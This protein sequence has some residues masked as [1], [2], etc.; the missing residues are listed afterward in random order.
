MVHTTYSADVWPAPTASGPLEATVRLPG[1][2]SLT[3]RELVLSALADRPSRLRDALVA[4]DTDLMIA[5]LRSFGVR[6]ERDGDD[7][8]V[9]PGPLAGGASIDVGLAGTLMRFLPPLAALTDGPVRFDGDERARLRPM[10]TTILSLRALG[11]EVDDD[12][13]AT[14]P[15]IVEGTGRVTGGPVLLDASESSQFVSGLLLSGPRFDDGLEIEHRGA[16]LPS[17]P[18]IEMTI[19]ALRRRGVGVRAEVDPADRRRALAGPP[20][21]DRRPGGRDRARPVERRAIPRRGGRRRRAG[22]RAGLAGGDDPGR[23]PAARLA[24]RVRRRGRAAKRHAHVAGQGVAAHPLR[25]VELD[26][27]EGG[28]L[29][30]T[31][32]GLAA[33]ADGTSTFTGIG[34]LRGHETDRLAAL[35]T[36]L[37]ALGIAVEEPPTGS[38]CTAAA[39]SQA[40]ALAQLRRPP[41]G[42][43]GSAAR[44]RDAR[45]RGRGRRDDREDPPGVRRPVAADAPV[46]WMTDEDEPYEEYDESD[47]RIRPNR[48]GTRPRTKQRPA[49]DAAVA[50]RVIAVDRGRMQV[51]V[52][53]DGHDERDVLATRARELGKEGVVAGDRVDIVGDLSGET[54]LARPDR[55]DPRARRRCCGAARTTPTRSSASSSR[56]PTSCSS[57][58]PPPTPSRDPRS[59]TATWSPRS[60]PASTRSC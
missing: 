3:N 28:E 8:L 36:E 39:P 14:M 15:F 23:R 48:K 55:A 17:I 57:S 43:H 26:L 11:V 4:R 30:P 24:R 5:A 13:R 31:L 47:V 41:H 59:S 20:A 42:D 9:T 21:R 52:D 35:A 56:T 49:Y 60:T 22:Q 34:H 45:P 53:E 50:G 44:P 37:G 1:S 16:R 27:G 32:V 25:P 38:S 29:A 7:L 19:D 54:G 46:S 58:S 51:L 10:A 18:H 33:L 2:K 12:G 40:I 6:I